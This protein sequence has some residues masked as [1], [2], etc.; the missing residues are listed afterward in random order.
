MADGNLS[1]QSTILATGVD[2]ADDLF[3]LFDDSAT[4]DDKT[5]GMIPSEL[6]KY[7]FSG[8]VY[9][10]LYIDAAACLPRETNGAEAATEELA[11]NDVNVDHFLFDGATE[12]AIQFKF[13]LPDSWDLGTVKAKFKWDGA[14]GAS[15]ADGVTWGISLRAIDDNDAIDAAF[16][17]S[18][19]T[20]DALHAVGDWHVSAASSAITVS[21]TPAKGK[22][23]LGEITRVVG[24]S[25]DTMTEDAKF[26]GVH[27]QF[28]RKFND[29]SAW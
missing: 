26:F 3:L 24:D 20:D 17:A 1:D 25:N 22:T 21:G 23:I 18:V 11:T 19:D 8:V 16:A 10:E 13:D 15:A 9:D 7:I 5:K 14:S 4:G 29:S 6:R 12:E 27:I 2:S 28:G